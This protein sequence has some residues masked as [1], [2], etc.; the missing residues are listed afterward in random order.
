MTLVM[1]TSAPKDR[2]SPAQSRPAPSLIASLSGASE[3]ASWSEGT[4]PTATIG[5]E[6]VD[7]GGDE[8]RAEDAD[9]QVALRVLGLLAGRR[10]GVEADVG[11]EDQRGGVDRALRPVGRARREVVAVDR[12]EADDDE[13][14]QDPR[15]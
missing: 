8:Q 13:E 15:P 9:R 5:H 2:T 14:D 7:Q 10:D 1:A 6:D 12:R 3:P 11:E 4:R